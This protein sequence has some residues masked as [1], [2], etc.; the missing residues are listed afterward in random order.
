[1]T[2]RRTLF[3][4]VLLPITIAVWAQFAPTS[5]RQIVG[6][7]A[8]DFRAHQVAPA[9][10]PP[11]PKPHFKPRPVVK[12]TVCAIAG[13]ENCWEVGGVPR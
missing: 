1:M 2:Y 11:A 3:W 13:T 12:Y 6:K 9:A 10:A 7:L 5:W 8:H 4:F